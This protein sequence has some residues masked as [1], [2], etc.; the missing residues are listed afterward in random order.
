M[1]YRSVGFFYFFLIR[2]S[3]LA[4]WRK[5]EML[6]QSGWWWK[7][8]YNYS[9]DNE[10]T[11][12]LFFLVLCN[13]D[14]GESYFFGNY[15]KYRSDWSKKNFFFAAIFFAAFFITSHILIKL[16]Q[17]SVLLWHFSC[18]MNQEWWFMRKNNW[19]KFSNFSQ[20]GSFSKFFEMYSGFHFESRIWIL[21]NQSTLSS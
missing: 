10:G 18:A 1:I 8:A 21:L 7:C 15:I 20:I 17:Y 2:G 12:K 14:S 13:C 4:C 5:V 16:R 19:K 11:I 6:A 9:V 3:K